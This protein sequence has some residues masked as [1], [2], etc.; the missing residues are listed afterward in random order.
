MK[1]YMD[2]LVETMDGYIE[3][4][5]EITIEILKYICM[6]LILITFPIWYLP[7]KFFRRK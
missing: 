5:S 1:R 6:M 2:E 4:I 7:Y 3:F